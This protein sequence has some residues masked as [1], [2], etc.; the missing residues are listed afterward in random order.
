MRQFHCVAQDGLDPP[1][2]G[3][4]ADPHCLGLHATSRTSLHPLPP[5]S[6]VLRMVLQGT[7]QRLCGLGWMWQVSEPVLESP[8]P[9][10]SN[11]PCSNSLATCVAERPDNL[12]SYQ[13]QQAPFPPSKTLLLPPKC[14][15]GRPVP[16]SLAQSVSWMFEEIITRE[17]A[18]MF[19]SNRICFLSPLD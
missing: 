11:V 4:T 3:G 1:V 6:C 10:V 2:P 13:P 15:D 12:Y 16:S 8:G 7:V 5:L 19:D 14:W 18:C 9:E 17:T